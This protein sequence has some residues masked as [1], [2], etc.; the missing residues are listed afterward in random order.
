MID[1]TPEEVQRASKYKN[2]LEVYMSNLPRDANESDIEYF[3][4]S[5]G[6]R[7]AVIL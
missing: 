1:L 6:A 7:M 4:G 5:R 2:Q 3:F